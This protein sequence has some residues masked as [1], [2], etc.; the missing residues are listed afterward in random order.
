[1]KVFVISRSQ[2]F[3]LSKQIFIFISRSFFMQFC[4]TQKLMISIFSVKLDPWQRYTPLPPYKKVL[5]RAAISIFALA[6]RSQLSP[7]AVCSCVPPFY[8]ISLNAARGLISRD[9][10]QN[11]IKSTVK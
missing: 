10:A 1:M 4:A 9:I 2:K 11:L 6:L 3:F 5:Y 7:G 8:C